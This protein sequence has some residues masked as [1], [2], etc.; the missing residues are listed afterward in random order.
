[1]SCLFCQEEFREDPSSTLWSDDYFYIKADRS[2]A[3]PGHLL[4]ISRRHAADWFALTDEEKADLSS[5]IVKM[6]QLCTDE[7]VRDYYQQTLASNPDE[8]TR[9]MVTFAL[10]H[11]EEMNTKCSG[12]NLGC[13]CGLDAG[14]TQMHFHYHLIPSFPGDRQFPTGGIRNCIFERGDYKHARRHICD[15]AC[16]QDQERCC[17]YHGG[18]HGC[19]CHEND[20]K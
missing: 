3:N 2:P 16:C 11:W 9:E 5:V 20:A 17:G 8:R 13:N 14:Q 7:R 15:C 6:Q 4:A 18:R 1:M 12:Y 10:E 19:C